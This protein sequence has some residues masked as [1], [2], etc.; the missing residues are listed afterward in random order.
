M[1]LHLGLYSSDGVGVVRMAGVWG[2]TCVPI[3]L[4]PCT[5]LAA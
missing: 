5:G 4:I 3:L 1:G 2:V